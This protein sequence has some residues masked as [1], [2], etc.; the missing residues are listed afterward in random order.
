MRIDLLKGTSVRG[1]ILAGGSGTR[2]FPATRAVS[3]Q[4]LPVY[5]KPMI[6]YPLST[7]MLAGIRDIL[8]I[9]TPRD[10]PAF[11]ELFNDGHELGLH[12]SYAEQK[13]PR[14]LAESLVI[15]ADF[16]GG[17]DVALILG[18][19]VFY[20]AGL[21]DMLLGARAEVERNGG[22][23]VFGYP[24]EDPSEFGVVEVDDAGCAVSLE[25]KPKNP[26]SHLAVPG[27]YFYD[28]RVIDVARSIRPS[29][30][31]ELEITSVNDMYLKQGHLKVRILSR[32][33]V[34]LDTGTHDN[35]LEAA[36]FVSIV[37]KRQG[38]YISCIEEIAF[39]KGYISREDL[40]KLAKK[41]SQNTAYGCHLAKI[42]V[43]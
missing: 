28:N 2:L 1:I 33:S 17:D 10:L 31:G 9:S 41:K 26:K 6:Y 21:S 34:W 39:R 24:V 37:Q 35:L 8:I 7:L 18:D 43:E 22:A 16:I 12:F 40:A 4:L 25:E 20:S 11:K 32:G 15:G 23:V 27:L 13:E 29:E 30:R 3:K 5:D 14:G 42:A 36:E 38:I 19:N